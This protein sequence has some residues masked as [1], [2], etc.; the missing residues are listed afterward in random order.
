M[1]AEEVGQRVVRRRVALAI[2]GIAVAVAQFFTAQPLLHPPDLGDPN[3]Y[4]KTIG[5]LALFWAGL[6]IS[7]LV[8]LALSRVNRWVAWSLI[9]TLLEAV[10]IGIVWHYLQPLGDVRFA[11]VGVGIV[12][13]M[14]L[15]D[16]FSSMGDP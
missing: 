15:A 14:V 2:M 12:G 7:W 5:V 6:W 13:G 10:E 1:A 11:L 3:Y 9:L 16:H 4:L 8:G